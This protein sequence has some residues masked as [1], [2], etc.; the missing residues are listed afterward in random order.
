MIPRIRPLAPRDKTAVMTILKQSIQ[1]ELHELEV[2][3]EVINDYL[4]DP[5]HSGYH[6]VVADMES[7]IEGYICYG[8]TPLT[9]GTWD[10][11]WIAVSLKNRNLGIGRQL[12]SFAEDKI[13]NVQGRLIIVE[14]SS[15]PSYDET[16][17]FYRN[18]GY[19]QICR[20]P[21]FYA[22]KD[23]KILYQKK[24]SVKHSPQ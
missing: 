17:S 13:K 23:D 15:K 12:M 16:N 6:I 1:F 11:Y 18:L 4:R 3:E 8:P 22:P 5:I 21:D 19:E 7:D 14:T 20:I 2:A 9:I 10:I 24:L